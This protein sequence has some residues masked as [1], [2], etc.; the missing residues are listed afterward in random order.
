MLNGYGRLEN[1]LEAWLNPAISEIDVSHR[2]DLQEA[3]LQFTEKF[4]SFCSCCPSKEETKTS[5]EK[6]WRIA[7]MGGVF[8]LKEF[9][10]KD[11]KQSVCGGSQQVPHHSG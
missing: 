2:P 4:S 6:E 1:I 10:L 9:A 11:E 5:V 8:F 3:K 7:A